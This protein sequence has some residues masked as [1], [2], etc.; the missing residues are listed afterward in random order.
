ML[1]RLILLWS[2]GYFAQISYALVDPSV[3][4]QQ[5]KNLNPSVLKL[6]LEAYQCALHVGEPVS[7]ETLSIIDFSLPATEKRLWVVNLKNQ[8]V[9]FNSLVAHGQGSGGMMAKK[10][11]NQP[12]SHASSIG[13]YLTGNP[14]MG[15]YGYSLR[16]FGL[17]SGFNDQARLRGVVVHGASYVSENYVANLGQIGLTWGCPAVPQKLATPIINTIKGGNLIFAYYPQ[18][19]WLKQSKFLHCS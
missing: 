8:K 18:K 17:E 4:Q 7:G 10:F 12:N 3:I 11:S 9:L 15:Q 6:A 2:L 16:L 19:S 1:I 14:Y 13:L 5:A